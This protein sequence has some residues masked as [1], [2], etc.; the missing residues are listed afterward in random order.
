MQYTSF[1]YSSD[2]NARY[3]L[4]GLCSAALIILIMLLLPN[5]VMHGVGWSIA[6]GVAVSALIFGGVILFQRVKMKDMLRQMIRLSKRAEEANERASH[7]IAEEAVRM[8]QMEEKKESELL[9]DDIAQADLTDLAMDPMRDE[10]GFIFRFQG[11]FFRM[12]DVNQKVVRIIYP[13]IYTVPVGQQNLLARILNRVNSAFQLIKLTAVPAAEEGAVTVHA[14]ADIL[15]TSKVTDRRQLL[16]Q[17]LST[18]FDA[19]HALALSMTAAQLHLEPEV[20]EDEVQVDI[21]GASLN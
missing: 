4:A 14:M 16:L 15:Y 11:G 21:E 1:Q 9:A 17:L 18:F 13:R 2:S 12:T 20:P 3:A 5:Q 10:N 7:L 6:L 19:Q 8:Q